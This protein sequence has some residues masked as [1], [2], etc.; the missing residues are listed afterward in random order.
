M[1]TATA[2]DDIASTLHGFA[3]GGFLGLACWV[4]ILR[5]ALS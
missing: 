4:V 3:I 1:T 5:V 2:L